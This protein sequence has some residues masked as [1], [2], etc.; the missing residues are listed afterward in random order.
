MAMENG[1]VEDVFPIKN[2]DFLL[3]YISLLEGMPQIPLKG[4]LSYHSPPWHH[5]GFTCGTSR[6]ST[7]REVAPRVSVA[8]GVIGLILVTLEVEVFSMV[9]SGSLFLV[10]SVI[11]NHPIGKDY[12]WYISG[13]YCQLGD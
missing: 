4:G 3:P 2:G 11:Y 10:G 13:T 5:P 9:V 1:P 6:A 12:K 8:G 7:G